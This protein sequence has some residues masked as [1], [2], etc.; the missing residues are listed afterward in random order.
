[1]KNILKLFKVVKLIIDIDSN[2][3][4][5]KTKSLG[6]KITDISD[7]NLKSYEYSD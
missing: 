2:L 4:N 1:M 7:E 5:W 3:R 6:E